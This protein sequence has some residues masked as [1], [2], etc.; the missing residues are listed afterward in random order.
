MVVRGVVVVTGQGHGIPTLTAPRVAATDAADREPTAPQG[1]VA[2]QGLEGVAR[3]RRFEPTGGGA[4]AANVLVAPYE[5]PKET[6]GRAHRASAAERRC[7]NASSRD[8]T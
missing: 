6:R 2:L 4:T 3:A 1:A 5:P 7:S 8:L